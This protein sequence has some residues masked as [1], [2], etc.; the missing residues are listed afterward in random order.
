MLDKLKNL[1]TN[2]WLL[3]LV[4]VVLLVR[5]FM[6]GVTIG[7]WSFGDPSAGIQAFATMVWPLALAHAAQHGINAWKD[8]NGDGIPDPP[9]AAPATTPNS[10]AA[11]T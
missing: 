1:S 7:T 2:G 3:I 4:V 6:T 5:V 11:K 9:D 10:A 8:V